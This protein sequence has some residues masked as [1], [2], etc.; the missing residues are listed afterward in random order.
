MSADWKLTGSLLRSS[1]RSICVFCRSPRQPEDRPH[2]C[3]R[4]PRNLCKGLE[5]RAVRERRPDT[6]VLYIG[7]G[8]GDWCPVASLGRGDVVCARRGLALARRAEEAGGELLAHLRLWSDGPEMW[9]CVNEFL[10]LVRISG[11]GRFVSD[12]VVEGEAVDDEVP[13]PVDGVK[14]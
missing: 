13:T 11:A 3:E 2:G 8:S 5:L 6:R 4:C 9:N 14:A 7:D 1:I 12:V 10:P